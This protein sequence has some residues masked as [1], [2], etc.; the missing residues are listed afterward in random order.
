MQTP[1]S[2]EPAEDGAE[3]EDCTD[4]SELLE[5]S[6]TFSEDELGAVFAELDEATDELDCATGELDNATI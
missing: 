2:D 1:L 4:F 5:D 6:A 3:D